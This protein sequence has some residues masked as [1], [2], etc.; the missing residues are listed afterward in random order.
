MSKHMWGNED[1]DWKA[2]DEAAEYLS[3]NVRRWARLGIWTKEKYGKLC[4]STTC[5]YFTEYDF[6]HHWVKPGHAWYRWP[7]WFRVWV[8]WP[9]GKAMKWMGVV[10]M[11][12][13]WQHLVLKFFWKRTAKKWTHVAE[14]ILDE[15]SFYFGEDND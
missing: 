12:Q 5:A 13:K 9:F 11:L 8:D 3:K 2:L 10:Y 1:F 4:V 15:Y 6:L 14:E 7:K